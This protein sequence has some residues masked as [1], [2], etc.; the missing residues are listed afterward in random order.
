ME[1]GTRMNHTE[2]SDDQ[3]VYVIGESLIKKPIGVQT[4]NKYIK[5]VVEAYQTLTKSEMLLALMKLVKKLQNLDVDEEYAKGSEHF[6]VICDDVL[7]IAVFRY[8]LFNKEIPIS[9]TK[10]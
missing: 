4:T 5:D 7:D 9:L 8:L 2:L 10:E 6:N 3:I 1:N